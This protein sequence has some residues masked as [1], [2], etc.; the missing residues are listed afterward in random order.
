MKNLILLCFLATGITV[1]GQKNTQAVS[2]PAPVTQKF[3]QQF[4]QA[5]DVKWK[6]NKAKLYKVEFKSGTTKKEH[7]AWFD[8]G[9]NL[10]KQKMD[11]AKDELPAAVKQAIQ[12]QFAG[13]TIHDT[14]KI[15]EKGVFSYKVE[16]KKKPEEREVTF[17]SAGKVLENVLS[18]EKK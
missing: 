2:V 3:Q 5:T 15:D 18:K 16:L 12:Q 13:Y 8:A 6:E 1:Y 11:I 7:D 9:G 17:S 10:V 4:P 14:D